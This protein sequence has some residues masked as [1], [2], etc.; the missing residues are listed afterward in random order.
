[1]SYMATISRTLIPRVKQSPYLLAAIPFSAAA[2]NVLMREATVA[3]DGDGTARVEVTDK[4]TGLVD[5]DHRNRYEQLTEEE[6]RTELLDRLHRTLPRAKLVSAEFIDIGSF[7]NPATIKYGFTVD[8]TGTAVGDRIILTPS[9]FD[10]GKATPFTSET[11][12]TPV[13]FPHSQKTVQ[14]I[15]FEIPEGYVVDE[16]PR[17]ALINE[18][19]FVLVTNYATDGKDLVFSRRLEIDAAT[20]AVDQYPRLRAFFQKVQDAD[21]QVIVLRKGSP[22]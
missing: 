19:P 2:K 10:A 4:G 21:R 7:D 9:I 16:M 12:L 5:L 15:R 1:M 20:W 11:R 3:F 18:G 14:R 17:S 22:S 13:H 8:E 6:R